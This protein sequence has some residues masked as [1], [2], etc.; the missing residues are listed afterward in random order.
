M[1]AETPIVVPLTGRSPV[2]LQKS[3]SVRS[4]QFRA[5]LKTSVIT[6]KAD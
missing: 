2:M 1:I 5:P 6:Y 4:G 3:T